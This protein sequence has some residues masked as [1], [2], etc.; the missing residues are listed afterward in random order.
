MELADITLERVL[1]HSFDRSIYAGLIARWDALKT[2]SR[3]RGE[4]DEPRFLLF[5]AHRG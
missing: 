2:L 4:G 5:G 1:F 3:G